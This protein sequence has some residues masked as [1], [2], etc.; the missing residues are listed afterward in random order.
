MGHYSEQVLDQLSF[1]VMAIDLDYQIIALN[2]MGAELLKVNKDDV[3][4]GNVYDLFPSAPNEVRHVERTIETHEEYHVDVMP[5]H[6]GDYNLYLSIQT[7]IL[8]E[9][10]EVY[11]A[12]V[13]FTD[14]T[15]LY[16]KQL[17]LIN[18]L[19]DMAVNV[20]PLNE[21]IALLP[22]QPIIDEVDFHYVLD[23]SIDRVSKMN[24]N[25]LL[26]D[27]S[28]ISTVNQEFL[29]KVNKLIKAVSL[30]GTRVTITGIRPVVAKEWGFSRDQSFPTEIYP[31]LKIALDRIYEKDRV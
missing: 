21:G 12:M 14:V 16:E 30:I 29:E 5:Y 8:K 9:N 27:F 28:A 25:D 15:A 31:N 4:G 18:R 10:D 26:I 11:G 2:N 6:W 3:M 20:I 22:L 24:V 13:E 17:K 23:K 1:G 19:E 7:R